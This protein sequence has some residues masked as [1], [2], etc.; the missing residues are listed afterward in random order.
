MFAALRKQ[1][2][3]YVSQANWSATHTKKET[4]NEIYPICKQGLRTSSMSSLTRLKAQ[5][6]LH[7]CQVLKLTP[8]FNKRTMPKQISLFFHHPLTK[9][10][11][12]GEKARG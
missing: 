11:L 7:I 10:T 9:N 4:Y 6:S 2:S 3:L 5:L 1:E 12:L 8:D